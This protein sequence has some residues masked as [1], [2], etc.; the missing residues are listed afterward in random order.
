MLYLFW[1]PTGPRFRAFDDH[2]VFAALPGALSGALL[3]G[4][5][6]IKIARLLRS[7]RLS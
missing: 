2:M 5:A 4:P 1:L 7:R 3:R 6:G